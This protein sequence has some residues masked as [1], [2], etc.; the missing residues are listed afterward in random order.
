M[1]KNYFKIALRTLIRNKSFTFINIAGLA[2][3]ISACLLIFLV[4]QFELSFDNFHP[5]RDRIYRIVSETKG[6]DGMNY[7]GGVPFPVADGLRNEFPELKK[8]AEIYGTDNAQIII[9][10]NN[11]S[12]KKKYK[13]ENG[14]FFTGPQFFS[15]FN[16]PWLIGNPTDLADPENAVV[17][18]ETAERYFGNWKS[19]LGKSIKLNNQNVYKIAGIIKNVPANSDFPFK[20]L[21]SFQSFK[22]QNKE[23]TKDWVSIFGS[24]YCFVLFPENLSVS[25]FNSFLKGFVKR[26]KP[27]EYVKE[28]LTVEPLNEMHFDSRF[29]N[30]NQR[31]FSKELIT[32]ISLISIFLLIIACVNFINLA[33]AQAVNRS[34][35]VGVRKVLGSS[36]R[37]LSFQF[38]SE[39]FIITLIS[40]VVS[41]VIAEIALPFLDNLL[42]L[43]LNLDFVSNPSIILFL[44]VITFIVTLMSGFYPSIILSGFN[45]IA[46]FKSKATLKTIGGLSLRRSLVIFQFIIAQVLIFCML[47]VVNQMNYFKN[48]SYGFTKA[49]VVIVPV[50][51]DSLSLLKTSSLKNQLVRQS[52]VKEVSFSTFTPSDNSHWT[53]DFN[54]NNSAKTTDFNA[55]LKWADNDYFKIYNLK[56]LAGKPYADS[57][58]IRNFVVNETLIRKLGIKDPNDAVGK[59]ISLWNGEH[60]GFIVGV[61]KDF[62]TGPLI[63]PVNP[64]LMSSW[65]AVYGIINIKILPIDIKNTLSS[66]EK[67][68]NDSYPDY[69]YE[70]Q[71]L[72][73]KLDNFYKHEDQ[74]SQ[75]Y[76]I[77]AAIAIF[78]S[79]LGLYGLISFMT[80]QR[81]KEVGI[82]KVLG[83]SA[84]NIIYLFSREFTILI[85]I[86]FL[87]SSPV[88]YYLMHHWLE[89]FAYKIQISINLFLVTIFGSIIIAWITVGYK[90]IKAAI[91][92]PVKSLKYE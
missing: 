56:F 22:N 23:I 53:S 20:I 61:V 80:I 50:P 43:K 76:K 11:K 13:E 15:I 27:P 54:F 18:K 52:G 67:I 73:Q 79:C 16:F 62:N 77:F 45:P 65:R 69:I 44:I 3:G 26:H 1:L 32:A 25:K 41:A 84:G 34:R 55:E 36:R 28:N 49:Q 9:L 37:Q 21:L 24:N 42:Q 75:L 71:F 33:T 70:Y 74:L 19:A 46:A 85:G 4:V 91:A 87:F 82:R 35:E 63:K 48:A 14:V 5:N 68:W 78:I 39:I 47:V 58:T 12:Y 89:N 90:A 38:F 88:S 72:N 31:T 17:T 60:A 81:T 30:Y 7:S 83:A 64:V 92:N 6:P 40:I 57:D 2:V 59:K 29:G 86:A 8:V 51:G 66:I 10:N